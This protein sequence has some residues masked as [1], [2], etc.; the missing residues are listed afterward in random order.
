MK[1]LIVLVLLLTACTADPTP[2]RYTTT[3]PPPACKVYSV[4]YNGCDN[5]AELVYIPKTNQCFLVVVPKA[6]SDWN[7]G[8]T[9]GVA[10]TQVEPEACR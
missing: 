1:K 8:G 9:M 2:E 3:P 5:R 4:T 7:T 6:Y 10:I